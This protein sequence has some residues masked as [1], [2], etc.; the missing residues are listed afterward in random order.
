MTIVEQRKGIV[1]RQQGELLLI[2]LL[3]GHIDVS[4][5]HFNRLSVRIPFADPAPIQHPRNA[6]IFGD[7]AVQSLVIRRFPGDVVVECL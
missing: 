7:H 6:A 4:A 5:D 3:F 1:Q 2:L